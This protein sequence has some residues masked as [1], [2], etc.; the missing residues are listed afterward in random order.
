MRCKFNLT[1]F[2]AEEFPYLKENS[3]LNFVK[4]GNVHDLF[5]ECMNM[6]YEYSNH[7]GIIINDVDISLRVKKRYFLM[8]KPYLI[9]YLMG[10][11]SCNPVKKQTNKRRNKKELINF[12]NRFP[13]FGRNDIISDIED[14]Q[15]E[16]IFSTDISNNI[17]P[18]PQQNMTRLRTNS[19]LNITPPIIPPPPPPVQIFNLNNNHQLHT[20]INMR[21]RI[22]EIL[23]MVD[24]G[25]TNNNIVSQNII[26]RLNNNN[27]LQNYI[28]EDQT[29]LTVDINIETNENNTE[30]NENN[31]EAV[32]DPFIPTHE[33]PRTPPNRHRPRRRRGLYNFTNIRTL[34]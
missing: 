17:A 30:T 16:I 32:A 19:I 29:N 24:T 5:E 18:P 26:N 23:T 13:R 34:R 9:N 8:L 31:T 3:I 7:F 22:R 14:E 28:N 20:T 4:H 25:I 27:L 10:K 12:F 2:S 11:Y 21:D 6:L 33:I 15:E 1:I